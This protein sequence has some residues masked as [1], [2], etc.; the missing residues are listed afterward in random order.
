VGLVIKIEGNQ[1]SKKLEMMRR[2]RES[3]GWQSDIPMRLMII[4][5]D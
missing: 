1:M 4:E 5:P 2:Y 3:K